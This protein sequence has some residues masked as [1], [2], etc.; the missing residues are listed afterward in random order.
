MNKKAITPGSQVANW[1]I[2]LT[3]FLVLYLLFIPP[4][5]R[6]EIL[7]SKPLYKINNQIK[8]I[9]FKVSNTVSY[10]LEVTKTFKYT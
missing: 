4:D 5:S 10:V 9:F 6:K 3:L 8:E 1:M 2:L 7:D